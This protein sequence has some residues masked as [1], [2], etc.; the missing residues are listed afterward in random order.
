MTSCSRKR[1][2]ECVGPNCEWITGKGCKS[3][4]PTSSRARSVQR[5]DNSPV[6]RQRSESC[7]KKRKVNCNNSPKCKWTTGRGCSP[8]GRSPVVR[9]SPQQKVK[10][11]KLKKEPCSQSPKC[12][13]IKGAGC[14][15]KKSI[16]L[17]LSVYP[18]DE[19]EKVYRF[20]LAENKYA[21]P[22]NVNDE[23]VKQRMEEHYRGATILEKIFNTNNIIYIRA[24]G[25]GANGA[26]Y[27]VSSPEYN[28]G[29]MM[30]V[31]FSTGNKNSLRNEVIMQNEFHKARIGAPKVL[32][33]NLFKSDEEKDE[34]VTMVLGMTLD[35]FAVK[36]GTLY[37]ILSSQ[38]LDDGAIMHIA[39]C[40]SKM[41]QKMQQNNLMH[42]DFHKKNI[43]FQETT[44]QS[45]T[46]PYE[47]PAIQNDTIVGYLSPLVIDFGFSRKVKDIHKSAA[48][49]I[50]QF[51]RT[52]HPYFVPPQHN[53]I[54]MKNAKK[55]YK[56]IYDKVRSNEINL[57]QYASYMK[58]P[59][60]M[61]WRDRHYWTNHY[62]EF[63]GF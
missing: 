11:T 32:F 14:R 34:D 44:S 1:K 30:I 60:G 20:R 35:P 18:S 46:V 49:D 31:K 51:V 33:S 63:R 26:V 5:R 27:I 6:R 39:N 12:D 10:C 4:T 2:A 17:P 8:V 16:E 43:G 45:Q 47:F 54:F 9:Q 52:L 37:D 3:K 21:S 62:R 57:G 55:L 53:K 19:E 48:A 38:V 42:G 58:V 41:I 22:E 56:V 36:Y 7:Y 59:E 13:W 61:D 28:D 25:E 24:L 40:L 23:W 50:F 29:K 15:N